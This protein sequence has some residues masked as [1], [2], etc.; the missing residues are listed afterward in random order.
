MTLYALGNKAP[1]L[2]AGEDYWIAPDANLIGDVRIAS[3]VSVWFGATLRGDSEPIDVG[4]GSNVQDNSVLHTDP[5]YPL[6]IGEN[7][8]IGHK[9]MLHGCVI[10]DGALIG[11]GAIVLNGARIGRG[12]LVGAGALITEGNQIP[13]GSLVIGAPARVVRTLGPEGSAQ[14]AAA[15]EHYRARI[16][17]YRRE[18]RRVE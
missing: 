11:M 15:A 1:V 3:G 13:E 7:C 6:L 14:C 5:G 9:V 16:G 12:S 4:A 8:T 17:R 10:E 2:P 18:L